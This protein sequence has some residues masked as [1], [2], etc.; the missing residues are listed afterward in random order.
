MH[1]QQRVFGA[2]P[3]QIVTT[4]PSLLEIEIRLRQESLLA[5]NVL[6]PGIFIGEPTRM[7]P[8]PL[9]PAIAVLFQAQQRIGNFATMAMADAEL[10]ELLSS[11]LNVTSEVARA[12]QQ[13]FAARSRDVIRNDQTN[14]D[15]GD[16]QN[17]DNSSCNAASDFRSDNDSHS[18][19]DVKDSVEL[20]S[21]KRTKKEAKW[22]A[23]FERLK[24]YKAQTGD[25]M[26][27]RGYSLNTRLASWVAEQRWDVQTPCSIQ[28]HTNIAVRSPVQETI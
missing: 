17:N 25:C 21:Y 16:H 27:P 12:G 6:F 19:S 10:R 26:V 3:C 5:Q 28:N 15:E 2:S 9:D 8:P 11:R 23:M 1:Q 13:A 14:D 18:K 24:E 20:D 22:H 4:I 7:L